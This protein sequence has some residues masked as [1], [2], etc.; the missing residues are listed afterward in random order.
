MVTTVRKDPAFICKEKDGGIQGL[1]KRIFG[2]AREGLY[3]GIPQEKSSRKK[4][5]ITNAEL[6]Y[7][8]THGVR[9]RAMRQEMDKAMRRGAKYSAAYAMY[10]QAHGSPLWHS[11]PRPIIE[12]AIEANKDILAAHYSEAMIAASAGNMALADR[13]LNLTGLKG[14]AL[15]RKWF[16]DPRNGWAPNSP[17]TI[18]VKGS[19]K[20]LID[21]GELRKSI[22]Y[23]IRNGGGND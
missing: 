11:P 2:F 18:K 6:T 7:V 5:K 20:P 21:T 3:I 15:V 23:V 16:D 14:Q 17:R 22:T 10:I 19:A 8:H 1:L 4:A 9:A 12:P 13:E